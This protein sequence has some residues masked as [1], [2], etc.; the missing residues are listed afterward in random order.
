MVTWSAA[1]AV[2][3]AA[4]VTL[5]V[6]LKVPA[7]VGLPDSWPEEERLKPVGSEPAL[8]LHV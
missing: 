8:T 7:E 4:S 6:K 2:P 5:T 1:V 3:A